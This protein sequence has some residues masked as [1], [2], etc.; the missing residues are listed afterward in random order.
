MN[1]E[2]ETTAG[3]V[4]GT[5]RDG[6][7]SYK[8]IPYGASTA[9]AN[10]FL[11]PRQP[12]PWAGVRDALD[13]V[14]QAPQSRTGF[15][16]RS[17]LMNFASPP[18]PTP[19][20]ED[21]LTLH[22]WTP[23]T[24]GRRPVMVWFHGGA[25]AFGSANSARLDGTNLARRNEVVVVCVNQRLNLFGHFDLS[26]V[27]GADY[28]QSGNA[29]ALDM[30]AAL[31]WVRDNIARFGGDPDCVMA[32][33]E[34]GGGA[35]VSVLMAMPSA[36]GLFHRAAIQSGAAV[37]LR[38]KDRAL[39][40]TGHIL[41]ELGL[42]PAQWRELTSVPM[43]RLKAAIGPA[44]AA[45]G[46]SPHLLFD[47]YPFGP[48]VDGAL[49]PNHPFDPAAP[50]C[51]AH[52][53]LLIGDTTEEAA[54]FI[55]SADEIWHDTLT[56]AA[57]RDRVAAVAGPHTDRVV[58]TYRRLH[59]GLSP[60]R[61]LIATLTDSNFRIRSLTAAARRLA[62]RGSWT[63]MYSF[64]H[65]SLAF[66]GRLG[67]PHAFDVPFTFNTIDT[68]S[69]IDRTNEARTLGDVMS[70]TWATF[71]R[72]G[73]PENPF[74]SDWPAYSLHRRATF[75]LDDSPR[76]VLDPAAE[77]RAMWEEIASAR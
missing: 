8:A 63:W 5:L 16:R 35:K 45:L 77:T 22:V 40:L 4:R 13:Y 47:R 73:V 42:A 17:E 28:A 54:T 36:R 9:G 70:T 14:A 76:V 44:E 55:G 66:D 38:T 11:P 53:P 39:A 61:R 15:E 12:A 62:L 24:T 58:E 56:E 2:V 7:A 32:F 75:V 27:A 23:G 41:R 29:G 49:I 33:G 60:A 57:M 65:P 46:R 10:R 21:C 51:S 71:A 68:L 30:I 37:R 1:P 59:P 26:E 43:E 72:T 48:V 19:E 3:R 18:D 20:S 74:V 67:C 34:S 25:F 50:D 69:E 6:V 64:A 31:E 52:V